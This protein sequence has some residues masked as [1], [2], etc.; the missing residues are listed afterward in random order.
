MKKFN[1]K[2]FL[3]WGGLAFTL[4]GTVMTYISNKY[5]TEDILQKLVDKKLGK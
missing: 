3:K 2:G 4:T 5:E 1:M